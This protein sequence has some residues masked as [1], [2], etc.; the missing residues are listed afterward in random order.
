MQGSPG[1]NHSRFLYNVMFH[2]VEVI[3]TYGMRG[4]REL[5]LLVVSHSHTHKGGGGEEGMNINHS[6][7]GIH[8]LGIILNQIRV[9]T[10]KPI[11]TFIGRG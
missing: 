5:V 1:F 4:T 8:K 11:D 7:M 3:D 9:I 2:S 10:S 6:Q